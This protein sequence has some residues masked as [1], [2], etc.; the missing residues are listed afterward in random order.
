LGLNEWWQIMPNLDIESHDDAFFC[1]YGYLDHE[2]QGMLY[3]I[4]KMKIEGAFFL[5]ASYG[6]QAR[7]YSE[8]KKW[9]KSAGS[10]NKALEVPGRL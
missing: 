1:L 10:A 7:L 6:F 8:R 4:E 3:D 2:S 5:S 9:L